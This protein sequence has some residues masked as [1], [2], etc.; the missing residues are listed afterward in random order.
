MGTMEDSTIEGDSRACRKSGSQGHPM[1]ADL[2]QKRSQQVTHY[3]GEGERD[4]KSG[5]NG[6]E[7]WERDEDIGPLVL[8]RWGAPG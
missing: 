6:R 8:Q 3:P 2:I 1:R 4:E 5:F 7:E